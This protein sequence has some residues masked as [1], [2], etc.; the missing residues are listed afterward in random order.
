M[1]FPFEKDDIIWLG[2]NSEIKLRA[3]KVI[4]WEINEYEQEI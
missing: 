3:D 2:E 4:G 1:K